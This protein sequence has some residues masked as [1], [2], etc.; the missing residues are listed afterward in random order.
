MIEL[1]DM[2]SD[3]VVGMVIRGKIEKPGIEKVYAEVNAKLAK[4]DK[5]S[6]YV[7]IDKFKGISFDAMVVDI[8]EGIP[9]LRKLEKKA[10][11]SSAKWIEVFTKVGDKLWPSIEVKHFSPEQKE[12][13]KAWVIA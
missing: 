5:I 6:V 8:K 7:E 9:K 13:A 2:Q 4:Q 11:V 1:L 12:E 10:V 3:K